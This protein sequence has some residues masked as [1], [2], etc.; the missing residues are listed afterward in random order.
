MTRHNTNDPQKSLRW[1]LVMLAVAVLG[2][3]LLASAWSWSPLKQWLDV[4]RVVT[5]LQ[6]MGQSVGAVAAVVGFTVALILAVPL[7]FLTLVTIVAFGPTAGF[8]YAMAAA[9]MGA[10]VTFLIGKLMGHE[11]VQ[12][13]GGPR[14]NRISKRLASHGILS[15]I[16]IRMVPIAPFAVVNIVAGATHLSLRDLMV[17][18]AI[19]MA[20]GTLI[21]AFFIDHIV[22]ALKNPSPLTWMLAALMLVLI[23]IGMWGLRYWLRKTDLTT[24]AQPAADE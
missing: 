7:T 16:A 10:G 11:V 19:G 15:V 8:F 4:A 2:M 12:R 21:M 5:A 9:V 24:A 22:E 20:P 14:V 23:I 1:R 17:G 3:L 13:L 6:D 18:T